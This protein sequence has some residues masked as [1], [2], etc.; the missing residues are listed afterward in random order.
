MVSQLGVKP[1]VFTGNVTSIHNSDISRNFL[2]VHWRDRRPRGIAR[3][4]V[5]VARKLTVILHR[6]WAD[7]S[8][9]RW[10]KQAAAPVMAAA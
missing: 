3:A 4:R 7:G 9:F 10:G 6:M 5:A 2:T 1:P 8:E